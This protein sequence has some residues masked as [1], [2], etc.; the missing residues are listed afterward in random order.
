MQYHVH[1]SHIPDRYHL[2]VYRCI[3]KRS[4]FI[5]IPDRQVM[6]FHSD[7]TINELAQLL[8]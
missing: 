7:L 8:Q 5:T 4:D 3:I 2:T 6:E 1:R